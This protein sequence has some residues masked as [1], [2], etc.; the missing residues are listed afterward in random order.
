MKGYMMEVELQK[1]SKSKYSRNPRN[2]KNI[3]HG[4][5]NELSKNQVEESI[6]LFSD[7]RTKLC[8]ICLVQHET[9]A[10]HD[11]CIAFNLSSDH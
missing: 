8:I 10:D 5:R 11:Y 4:I 6:Y 2:H 7:H 3:F 9:V 1:L